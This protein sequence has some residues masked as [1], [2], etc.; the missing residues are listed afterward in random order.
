MLFKQKDRRVNTEF[1]KNIRR[2]RCGGV[3]SY[4]VRVEN[5]GDRWM[6]KCTVSRCFAKNIGQ[7]KKETILGWNRLSE[8]LSR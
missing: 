6:I 5:C 2:C 4:P 7:G 8:H 1:D 3:A